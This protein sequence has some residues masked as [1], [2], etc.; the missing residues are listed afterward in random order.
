LRDSHKGQIHRLTQ[1]EIHLIAQASVLGGRVRTWRDEIAELFQGS[2]SV[3]QAKNTHYFNS[4]P[5]TR[6]PA[7]TAVS[8]RPIFR[9]PKSPTERA[10]HPF[11]GCRGTVATATGDSPIFNL[12]TYPVYSLC[13]ALTIPSDSFIFHPGSTLSSQKTLK[14]EL[15]VGT[16]P[17]P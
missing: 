10:R 11:D 8:Q 14:L 16:V 15:L 2:D 7:V 5:C 9:C 17:A 12:F 3:N 13:F 6:V 4:H 1:A